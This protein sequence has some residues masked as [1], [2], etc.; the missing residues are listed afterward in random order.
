MLCRRHTASDTR[1]T[2]AASMT[3]SDRSTKCSPIC[4]AC[5]ATSWVSVSVA[6][7][8]EHPAEAAPGAALLLERA[9]QLGGG[10]L[11]AV[12]QDVPELL[13]GS[14]IGAAARRS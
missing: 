11:T 5:A 14:S 13:H 1:A 4:T 2:A 6:A 7:L 9:R 12:E 10:H 3:T 8:H